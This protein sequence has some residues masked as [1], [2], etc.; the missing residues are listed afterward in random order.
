M[1]VL[2]LG[3]LLISTL[4]LMVGIDY[5]DLTEPGSPFERVKFDMNDFRDDF[6]F[7]CVDLCADPNT[8]LAG[9]RRFYVKLVQRIVA[10]FPSQRSSSQCPNLCT[11]ALV[12]W[13][14]TFIWRS[15]FSLA[16][17][18]PVLHPTRS[19]LPFVQDYALGT[20]QHYGCHP[21]DRGYRKRVGPPRLPKVGDHQRG[22]VSDATSELP[23]PK[24]NPSIP[25]DNKPR[26]PSR[27]GL[28]SLR[29]AAAEKIKGFMSVLGAAA[30]KGGGTLPVGVPVQ[31]EFAVP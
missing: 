3:P 17:S 19:E 2:R 21:D 10:Q 25:E 28:E 20:V 12:E 18:V 26:P 1:L 8:I 31:Y 13:M 9:V 30:R 16:R 29:R 6:C 5:A 27:D 4:F 24:S 11:E 22:T 23:E 14:P 7:D 15:V